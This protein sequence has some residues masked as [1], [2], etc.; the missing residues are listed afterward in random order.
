MAA[1]AIEQTVQL[2]DD[3]GMFTMIT[4]NLLDD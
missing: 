2:A 4:P 1:S 3:Y